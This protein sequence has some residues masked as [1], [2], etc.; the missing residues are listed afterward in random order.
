MRLA[1]TVPTVSLR[2]AEDLP[3]LV[4]LAR[5]AEGRT[6]LPELTAYLDERTR[7][8]L[9][10]PAPAAPPAPTPGP[11]PRPLPEDAR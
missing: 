2:D 6:G 7:A 11:L 1:P 4:G 9:D 8:F 5:F 3:T 10:P